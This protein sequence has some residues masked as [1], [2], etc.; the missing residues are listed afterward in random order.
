VTFHAPPHARSWTAMSP[1][2]A[3]TE[4]PPALPL[5][6]RQHSPGQRLLLARLAQATAAGRETPGR[7]PLRQQVVYGCLRVGPTPSALTAR[8]SQRYGRAIQGAL[9]FPLISPPASAW[10][11]RALLY[12]DHVGTVAPSRLG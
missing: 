7:R 2:R 1:E 11:T 3:I 8:T 4:S 5:S 6:G 10:L 9:D 12:W